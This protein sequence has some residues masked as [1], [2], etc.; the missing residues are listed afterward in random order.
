M[1]ERPWLVIFYLYSIIMNFAFFN[2]KS[3]EC[4]VIRKLMKRIN[5]LD[6]VN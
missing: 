3:L 4:L 6:F 5:K 1:E 2:E